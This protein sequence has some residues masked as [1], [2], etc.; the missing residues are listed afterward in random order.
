MTDGQGISRRALLGT[1]AA[2]GVA[3]VALTAG[4][5]FG[6]LAPLNV[7]APRVQ[8]DGPQG[9]PVNMTAKAA[10]VLSSARAADWALTVRNG[11]RTETL[12]RASLSGLPQARATLPIACVEG[13]STT[14]QW[15]GVRMR[16]LLALVGA[17]SGATLLI[18]SLQPR[19]AYRRT[20]MGPEFAE[21]PTTLVALTL[22]G[23]TL[24]LDHG[25]PARVIA[26]GRPGVLQTKWLASIEVIPG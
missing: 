15:G 16:D 14:A 20:T 26:P 6:V 1:I 19:G 2:A 3:T 21:D 18:S 8:G 23:Q 25:Y 4:Q 10:G 11:D 5:S 7:F 13:W 22:G 17:P 12:D 24:D 9:V